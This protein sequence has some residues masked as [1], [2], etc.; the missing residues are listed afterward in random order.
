MKHHIKSLGLIRMLLVVMILTISGNIA[1]SQTKFD[2][3]IFKAMKDELRRTKDSLKLNNY[4][5]PFF[6]SYTINRSKSCQIVGNLGSIIS[7]QQQEWS[8]VG[9]VRLLLGN[10]HETSDPFYVGGYSSLRMPADDN[11]DLIRRR[12]WEQSDIAYKNALQ[13]MI[14]KRAYLQQN[15]LSSEIQN[16][17]EFQKDSISRKCILTKNIPEIDIKKWEDKVRELSAIFKAFPNIFDSNVIFSSKDF[18]FY[19]VNTEGSESRIPVSL[20]TIKLSAKVINENG[21][22]IPHSI[23]MVAEDYMSLPSI[24]G[25]IEKVKDFAE[26]VDASRSLADIEESFT[27]PVLFE[28]EASFSLLNDFLLHPRGGLFARR[29]PVNKQDMTT[30]DNKIGKEY[31]DDRISVINYSSLEGEQNELLS[32]K[33]KIDAECMLPKNKVVLIQ[34]GILEHLLNGRIPT[35]KTPKSTGS[36]RF[37]MREDGVDFVTAPGIIEIQVSKGIEEKKMKKRYL[38]ELKRRDLKYGYIIRSYNGIASDIFRID[39]KNGT[40]KKVLMNSI[41]PIRKERYKKMLA[42]S[43]GKTIK[44]YLWGGAIHSS[45]IYPSSVIIDGVELNKKSLPKQNRFELRP[46]KAS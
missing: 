32:G 12:L 40:E 24:E 14:R 9:S 33:Y 3:N 43:T 21:V 29:A 44:N 45:L 27:G 15:P 25:L 30:L 18:V 20:G 19:T 13:N 22:K 26:K 46:P 5:L 35:L 17:D 39:V 36:S 11:Y 16:I 23:S 10:Y 34:D 31:I 2:S 6:V 7:S 38:K 42:I 37:A 41:R 1:Y 4:P 8:A 28:K